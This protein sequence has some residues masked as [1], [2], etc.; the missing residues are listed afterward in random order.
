MSLHGSIVHL[1][2]QFFELSVEGE[3]S[4]AMMNVS[5]NSVLGTRI[6]WLLLIPD[7]LPVSLTEPLYLS[8][9]GMC[10]ASHSG[11]SSLTASDI[12]CTTVFD[13]TY[14]S[15]DDVTENDLRQK[16]DDG[17]EVPP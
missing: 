17:P 16:E 5:S 12:P 13:L 14:S 8:N 9:N 4:T 2:I 10:V 3:I 7:A 6:A 1:I 11:V 15:L